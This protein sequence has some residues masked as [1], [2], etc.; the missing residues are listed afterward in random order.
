MHESERMSEM[1]REIK[2][3]TVLGHWRTVVG[4]RWAKGGGGVG[5][6][7]TRARRKRGNCKSVDGHMTVRYKKKEL[8][9]TQRSI[10]LFPIEATQWHN[11]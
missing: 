10:E 5:G 8:F 4:A 9:Y 11:S 3:K 1:K 7:G 2:S 6:G